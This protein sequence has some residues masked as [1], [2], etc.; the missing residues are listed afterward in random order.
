[1]RNEIGLSYRT[2]NL[3]G[4]VGIT[5]N[6]VD[7]LYRHRFCFVPVYRF[8][9]IVAAYAELATAD[10]EPAMFSQAPVPLAAD[11][12]RLLAETVADPSIENLDL[13]IDLVDRFGIGAE[14]SYFDLF[15]EPADPV[16]VAMENLRMVSGDARQLLAND[17]AGTI[18]HNVAS[19]VVDTLDYFATYYRPTH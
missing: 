3:L 19:A 11:L 13:F 9:Q 16:D 5:T 14:T 12:D 2:T 15:L 10:E 6:D 1:M 7:R 17:C 4:K 18:A 8:Q